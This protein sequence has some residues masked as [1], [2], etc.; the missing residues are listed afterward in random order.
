MRV[1]IGTLWRMGWCEMGGQGG[2][3]KELQYELASDLWA[4]EAQ[5]DK[6]WG[7]HPERRSVNQSHHPP[8][9]FLISVKSQQC[10]PNY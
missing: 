6:A 7:P 3:M 1:T 5:E 10:A 4:D 2:V 8:E 9:C